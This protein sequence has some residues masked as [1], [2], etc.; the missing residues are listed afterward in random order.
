M[1][2][3]RPCRRMTRHFSQ[4]LFTDGWTFMFW[5]PSLVPL[6]RAAAGAARG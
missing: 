2:I 5:L 4:I 3:T 6:G 1:I